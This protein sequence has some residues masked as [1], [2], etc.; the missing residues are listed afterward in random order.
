MRGSNMGLREAGEIF[1]LHI[2]CVS[3]GLIGIGGQ[4]CARFIQGRG[5][6]QVTVREDMTDKFLI[7]DLGE[8]GV[9]C[10]PVGALLCSEGGAVELGVIG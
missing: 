10:F 6:A 8:S 1:G 7:F 4:P 9:G 5:A 3:F 2:E